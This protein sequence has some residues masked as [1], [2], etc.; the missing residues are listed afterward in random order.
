MIEVCDDYSPSVNLYYN[1]TKDDIV[2][3]ILETC[4]F[5]FQFIFPYND[6]NT[7]IDLSLYCIGEDESHESTF[8]LP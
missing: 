7:R 5:G 8:Q 4:H 2:R 3:D 6:D 1:D